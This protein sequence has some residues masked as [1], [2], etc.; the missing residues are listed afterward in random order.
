[1]IFLETFPDQRLFIQ[2]KATVGF[3]EKIFL[4][5]LMSILFIIIMKIMKITWCGV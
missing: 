4:H 3:P 5:V 2:L 1:M